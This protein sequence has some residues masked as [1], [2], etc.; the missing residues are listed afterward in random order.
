LSFSDQDNLTCLEVAA[1]KK[2]YRFARALGLLVDRYI[3][4][5]QRKSHEAVQQFFD[6]QRR[7]IVE[8][9]SHIKQL[10]ERLKKG[11]TQRINFLLLAENEKLKVEHKEEIKKY[12]IQVDQLK[13][14]AA[15]K[16]ALEN[17]KSNEN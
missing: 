13:K 1:Q 15:G 14:E 7:I 6:E 11:T 2:E 16:V 17:G 5:L 9:D 10:E 8:K 3:A 12:K 4:T